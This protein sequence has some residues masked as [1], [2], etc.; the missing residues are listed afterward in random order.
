MVEQNCR[1][2]QHL[3]GLINQEKSLAL[4]AP[5]PLNIVCF[6]FLD[7]DLNTTELNA[8]NQEILIELQESGTAVPSHTMING[9]FAIR[10]AF[11]NHRTKMADIDDFVS[12]V[13][14]IGRRKRKKA[15][16]ED[17]RSSPEPTHSPRQN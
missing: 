13:L 11:F 8:L 3:A 1:Q 5:V 7:D 16:A 4:L 10:P 14:K 12:A 9:K 15:Q 6:R 2:G 17:L